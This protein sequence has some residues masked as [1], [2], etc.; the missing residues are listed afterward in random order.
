[1]RTALVAAFASLLFCVTGH[2]QAF[3]LS[4]CNDTGHPL[5]AGE[6]LPGTI[7]AGSPGCEI[8]TGVEPT[9]SANPN[10]D[11]ALSRSESASRRFAVPNASA[12]TSL[13]PTDSRGI[14]VSHPGE[15]GSPESDRQPAAAPAQGRKLAELLLLAGVFGTVIFRT[16]GGSRLVEAMAR[17]T[18]LSRRC[19]Y[20]YGAEVRSSRKRGPFESLVLPLMLLAPFR[21]ASCFRRCYGF[22]FIR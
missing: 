8:P 21:C 7:A 2:A 17:P 3:A 14:R 6:R 20:C 12:L 15:P 10:H 19:R 9:L 18:W 5:M 11:E 13:A 22:M 16:L 1:M 4:Q